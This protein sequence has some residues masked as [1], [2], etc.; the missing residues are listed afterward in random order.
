MPILDSNQYGHFIMNIKNL[1]FSWTLL[2]VLFISAC[3]GGGSTASAPATP[4]STA[5]PMTQTPPTAPES[6]PTPTP[7][8]SS[9][10]VLTGV[11]IDS[12]VQGLTF[13]TD[14]QSGTTNQD[15]EFS[16][17]A[18]EQV[19]FSIGELQFP[20]VN[21][22]EMLSPLD[23]FSVTNV[24]DI[25]VQ[26]MARLLQ[27]LDQDGVAGNGIVITDDA[28]NQAMGLQVDFA[29]DE[30]DQQVDALVAN[31]G[32][33]YTRLISSQ[34]A[35]NHLNLSLG[36][37]V[38]MQS[39]EQPT[40]KQGYIG[41]FSNLAHDVA[42]QATIMDACTIEVTMFNFDGQAPNVQ[43]YAGQ[44]LMF[45]G[46]DAFA[47]GGRIDGRAYQGERVV[48]RLPAGKTLEDFDSLSVWCVEFAIDFG[49]LQFQAP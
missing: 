19:V 38:N 5:P 14:T 42:G 33:A 45:E 20:A 12:A 15:G 8:A 48:L 2:I 25:R 11:F 46:Q 47:I 36:N 44:N 35:I 6:S 4:T 43:F 28:H 34:A 13:K 30:F 49:S 10:E 27:T 9:P 21:G 39:C 40:T 7:E 18:G 17:I 23:V 29:S 37:E 31:S 41:E 24:N 16:Y 32:A 1:S 3:G 26:N 22:K